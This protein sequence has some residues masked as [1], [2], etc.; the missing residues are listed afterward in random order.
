[1]PARCVF[2]ALVWVAQPLGASQVPEY[3][4]KYRD[5]EFVRRECQPAA[6]VAAAWP[7]VGEFIVTP[8][9]FVRFLSPAKIWQRVPVVARRSDA[10][11]N[12]LVSFHP[13][14]LS[15]DPC[16]TP[17]MVSHKWSIWIDETDRRIKPAPSANDVYNDLG[18]QY[19]G[20]Y[21]PGGSGSS[22]SPAEPKL[23][24][25]ASRADL[26]SAALL[27]LQR[28]LRPTDDAIGLSAALWKDQIGSWGTPP[29]SARACPL[30]GSRAWEAVR[31]DNRQYV[32][33][34]KLLG[35]ADSTFGAYLNFF[36]QRSA[37]PTPLLVCVAGP[38]GGGR[39]EGTLPPELGVLRSLEE[40][41]CAVMHPVHRIDSPFHPG[42]LE[43]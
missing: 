36:C 35:L 23:S 42:H 12:M 37:V 41:W 27:S 39:F 9:T 24:S 30:D 2:V 32:V 16:D 15:S 8:D 7:N 33:K 38:M 4:E 1:M 18:A 40:L 31:C 6:V 3:L 34:L 26:E 11:N 28:A 21:H 22:S 10:P 14:R 19:Q 43:K 25:P 20:H 29:Y 5:G 13:Q 17:D